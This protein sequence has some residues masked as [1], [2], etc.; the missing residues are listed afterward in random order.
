MVAT[1]GTS[2]SL[3][4]GDSIW[5]LNNASSAQACQDLCLSRSWCLRAMH[6]DSPENRIVVTFSGTLR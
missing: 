4:W 2:W 5:D 1:P 6:R 3:S